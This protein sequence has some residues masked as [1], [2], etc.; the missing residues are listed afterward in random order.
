APGGLGDGQPGAD[1]TRHGLL[2][3]VDLA[4]AR[5]L[6]R[7]AHRPLLDLGH[8]EG[9]ADDD[10]G[11]HQ[12]LAVVDLLDE[13]AQHRLRDLEVSDD[14]VLERPDGVDVAG[15]APEHAL[16]LGADREDA[17]RGAIVLLHGD[18]RRL[19]ADDSLALHVYERVRRPEIDREIVREQAEEAIEY[20]DELR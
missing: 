8:A 13:V 7:L 16:G 15:R 2:A 6:R 14:A 19:V 18:D 4:R 20:P 11:P 10:A 12:G 5:R 17:A 1:A 3:Q 9:H